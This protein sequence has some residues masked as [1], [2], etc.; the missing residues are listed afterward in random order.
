MQ[1]RDTCCMKLRTVVC[2]VLL[3]GL[4]FALWLWSN[5]PGTSRDLPPPE[6]EAV[7][8]R[9][10]PT[11]LGAQP[12]TALQRSPGSTTPPAATALPTGWQQFRLS[13]VVRA[14][15]TGR[16]IPNARI[17]AMATPLPGAADAPM[18]WRADLATRF[19]PDLHGAETRTNAAG[20]YA[21]IVAVPTGS[22]TL[23][24]TALARGYATPN[25][26]LGWLVGLDAPA[27][28]TSLQVAGA[29]EGRLDLTLA[30]CPDVGGVVVDE[31]GMPVAGVEIEAWEHLGGASG[32]M[33]S[34]ATDDQGR[35]CI[36]G[37]QP[38][39]QN[40]KGS[41]DFRHPL[42]VSARIE[43]VFAREEAERAA[44]KVVLR[45]G[46]RLSGTLQHADGTA[47]VAVLVEGLSGDPHMPRRS[48]YTDAAGRFSLLGLRPGALI[49]RA[50]CGAPIS[51]LRRETT[52]LADEL[53]AALRLVPLS[54]EHAVSRHDMLGLEVTFLPPLACAELSLAP[55]A[56][57]LIT[58]ITDAAPEAM[59]VEA[60]IGD[61]LL[62]V[63]GLLCK[64]ELDVASGVVRR[65]D[66]LNSTRED[67][68][69]HFRGPTSMEFVLG[70][71]RDGWSGRLTGRMQVSAKHVEELRRWLAERRDR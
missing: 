26:H 33:T 70:V 46:L 29:G 7:D 68:G 13:G 64:S 30:A 16:G 45:P 47:A 28:R 51:V 23:D 41:V 49:V 66:Y 37:F 31:A 54:A 22:S 42:F 56:A 69:A 15:G 5:D 34:P 20:A 14:R 11:L 21:L 53:G 25:G 63:S 18:T 32:L 48:A 2:L 67:R 12:R 59:R 19:S 9:R 65:V 55:D 71:R 17:L 27:D 10:P 52:L 50:L 61:A 44:L 62:V 39:Q 60:R 3:A 8:G 6:G 40:A 43:D 24:V 1:A 36:H 58:K 38:G 57:M 4:G 35:F